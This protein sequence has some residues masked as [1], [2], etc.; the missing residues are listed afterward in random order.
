MQ[1]RSYTYDSTE[2]DLQ[3]A[4]NSK[5]K[6][7]REIQLDESFSGEHSWRDTYIL[8]QKYFRCI[9]MLLYIQ[10]IAFLHNPFLWFANV[11]LV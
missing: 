2:I 1:F 5:G 7:I 10:S 4:L 11:L 6:E 3:Y 9:F 8:K